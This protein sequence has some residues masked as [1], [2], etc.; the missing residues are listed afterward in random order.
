[1]SFRS[2]CCVRK[3]RSRRY[4]WI[5]GSDGDSNGDQRCDDGQ[6]VEPRIDGRE[7]PLG[8]TVS[9][10][11]GMKMR[12]TASDSPSVGIKLVSPVT[13]SPMA[14]QVQDAPS[15]EEI[16]RRNKEEKRRLTLSGRSMRGS[17]I[18]P[19]STRPKRPSRSL[20]SPIARRASP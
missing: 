19:W 9:P 7:I 8:E 13:D 10:G 11:R 2:G 1:M 4:F 17:A 5:K 6:H 18:A 14:R 3:P 16:K 20:T 12:H 15:A